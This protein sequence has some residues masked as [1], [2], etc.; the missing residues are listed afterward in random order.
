MKLSLLYRPAVPARVSLDRRRTRSLEDI[1][2][3][4]IDY[5][6]GGGWR[7]YLTQAGDPRQF[8]SLWEDAHP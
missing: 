3:T 8:Q 4:R 7:R 6:P 2:H 5:P 1:E